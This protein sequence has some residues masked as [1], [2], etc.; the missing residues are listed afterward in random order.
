M[1]ELIVALTA[2][3]QSAMTPARV[4]ALGWMVTESYWHQRFCKTAPPDEGARRRN[5]GKAANPLQLDTSLIRGDR[6]E[7]AEGLKGIACEEVK[8]DCENV[9]RDVDKIMEAAIGDKV[10]QC[11]AARGMMKP[12]C[13]DIAST[14]DSTDV[15][16]AISDWNDRGVAGAP[17]ATTFEAA[18]Q[19]EVQPL[20]DELYRLVTRLGATLRKSDTEFPLLNE[21]G[22]ASCLED[23]DTCCDVVDMLGSAGRSKSKTK[24]KGKLY[25]SAKG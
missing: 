18:R 25:G 12:E 3:E 4:K 10:L 8:T 2:L 17:I 7:L 20:E 23:L 9:I 22:I 16:S 19:D 5:R 6:C 15:S 1:A 11:G 21:K 24:I 13:Y 14:A